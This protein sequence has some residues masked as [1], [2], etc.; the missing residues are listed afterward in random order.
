MYS[1][2][3][4]DR[5]LEY[6]QSEIASS[7]S[8]ERGPVLCNGSLRMRMDAVH[9]TA[10]SDPAGT[11]LG[12]VPTLE[13][14]SLTQTQTDAAGGL[15]PVATR[16]LHVV[17]GVFRCVAA[18]DAAD[19][20]MVSEVM[21][22]R[23]S[24][25]CC[26][27]S[28]WCRDACT[29]EHRATIPP[30]M[31]ITRSELTI[32]N[33]SGVPLPHLAIEGTANG[34]RLAY[35]CVYACT[36][37]AY[38]GVTHLAAGE[39]SVT[40]V[41]RVLAPD[42]KV[43]MLHVILHGPSVV[44]SDAFAVAARHFRSDI[45]PS[46][47]IAAAQKVHSLRWAASWNGSLTL[48]PSLSASA[49]DAESVRVA[50]IHVQTATYCLFSDM[51]EPNTPLDPNC[52]RVKSEY[53]PLAVASVLALAPWLAWARTF[54]RPTAF[55]PMHEIAGDLVDAWSGF[56][57]TMDRPA[58]ELHF[59]TLRH[60]AHE[61][62]ARIETAD[63]SAITGAPVHTG[64]VVTLH[65][66]RVGEDGYTTGLVRQAFE[67]AKQMAHALRTPPDPAW[68]QLKRGLVVPRTGDATY[69]LAAT[70]SGSTDALA[71]LHPA[72][73]DVYGN[74][75]D[76]GRHDRLFGDNGDALVAVS[77]TEG[78]PNALAA[79]AARLSHAR[80][81]PYD[82]R[83]VVVDSCYAAFMERAAETYD[84]LWGFS[85]SESTHAAANLLAC[86]LYGFAGLRFQGHITRDGIHVVP[87]AL[88]SGPTTAVLPKEWGLVRRKISRGGGERKEYLTQNV[89][90]GAYVLTP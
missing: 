49:Q 70:P 33:V 77:D 24:P 52:S 5:V 27:Q 44:A 48:Q 68:T 87:A 85:A 34:F 45:S 88:V 90:D 20:A 21:A 43:S 4:T 32:R 60:H 36:Q 29:L 35:C 84:P 54:E 2:P 1:V 75:T 8:T 69:E 89:R 23:Q 18:S 31:Y 12:G 11:R 83:M 14:T 53:V 19:P 30:S 79:I 57:T 26:V 6:T 10:V 63:S 41:V 7:A 13:F 17:N 46:A 64:D 78:E 47:S 81:L 76:L 51:L 71:L 65:G 73:L 15:E 50:N 55:T 9:P 82:E 62:V 3:Y 56:R 67:A 40:S 16:A 22:L 37:A 72:V 86:V 25:S 59:Q 61:L 28:L 74:S 38:D 80:R 42:T 39:V 58:L 66:T